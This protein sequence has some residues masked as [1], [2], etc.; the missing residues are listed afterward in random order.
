[1]LVPLSV[2]VCMLGTRVSK[3][4]LSSTSCHP[5]PVLHKTSCQNSWGLLLS[6]IVNKCLKSIQ[7]QIESK[8]LPLLTT[9]WALWRQW[10]QNFCPMQPDQGIGVPTQPRWGRECHFYKRS[11]VPRQVSAPSLR[12]LLHPGES[13]TADSA[14]SSA[15]FFL[16]GSFEAF[17]VKQ[18]WD[19]LFKLTLILSAHLMSD[20]IVN[21]GTQ[22]STFV[23]E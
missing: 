4:P 8:H 7:E 14:I 11:M 18:N 1:M 15:H 19:L 2:P 9:L 13:S 21:A 3:A 20:L 10:L 22:P 17:P 16:P 23:R 6:V 5:T 12:D